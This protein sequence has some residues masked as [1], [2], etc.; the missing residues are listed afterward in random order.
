MAHLHKCPCCELWKLKVLICHRVLTRFAV[1]QGNGCE[2][3]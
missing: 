3:Q 1:M 2:K